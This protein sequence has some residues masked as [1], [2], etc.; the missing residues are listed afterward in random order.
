MRKN[1]KNAVAPLEAF[2][3]LVRGA[4]ARKGLTQ[5]R[6]AAGA[7]VS[8]K[9]WALL[10]KGEN[11]SAVFIQKVAAY[12]ELREIPL[13]GGLEASTGG[14][15]IDLA[16]LIHLAD[17][18]EKFAVLFAEQIRTFAYEAAMPRLERSENAEA[19]VSFV[20][21][22]KQLMEAPKRL[23][24]AIEHLAADVA[25]DTGTYATPA[26]RGRQTTKAGGLK[27]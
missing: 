10:E 14:G 5:Q 7:G 2:G 9:Q 23:T 1:G 16:A 24:R 21:G 22:A 12:L 18:F 3:L 26:K 8:R 19:I 15:G 6:A 11:V 17:V 13:G 27:R 25:G 20:A 4:R